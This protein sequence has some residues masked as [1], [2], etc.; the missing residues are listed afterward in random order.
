MM[1]PEQV[2]QLLSTRMGQY[3]LSHPAFAQTLLLFAAFAVLPVALFLA[4]AVVTF[5]ISA[6]GF[7]FFQ[8]RCDCLFILTLE[9]IPLVV[10]GAATD[11]SCASSRVP[12]VCWRL[13]PAVRAGGCGLLLRGGFSHL[14]CV[15]FHHLQHFQT[16]AADKSKATICTQSQLDPQFYLH[17]HGS[18]CFLHQHKVDGR[19]SETSKLYEDQ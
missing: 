4:F 15:L 17:S 19:E 9:L 8:G 13:G 10:G 1:S 5:I 12:V 3:L 6:A 14:Q 18:V 7:V 11:L 16:P 2:S